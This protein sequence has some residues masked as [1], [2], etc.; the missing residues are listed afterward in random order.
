[1]DPSEFDR[2]IRELPQLQGWRVTSEMLVGHK[3][4]GA[5]AERADLLGSTLPVAVECEAW[6]RVLS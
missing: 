3:Q 5:F 4:V 2:D 1:M 6:E